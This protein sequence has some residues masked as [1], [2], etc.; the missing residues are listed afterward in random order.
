VPAVVGVPVMLPVEDNVIPTGSEPLDTEYVYAAVPPEVVNAWLYAVP[1]VA[2]GR[3]DGEIV[4][5]PA[6]D[7]DDASDR[8]NHR[9]LR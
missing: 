9:S 2:A 5:D 3:V 7:V 8:R 1:F 4:T 6:R